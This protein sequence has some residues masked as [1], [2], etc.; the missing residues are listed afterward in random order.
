MSFREIGIVTIHFQSDCKVV[1]REK[2]PNGEDKLKNSHYTS[3]LLKSIETIRS[4]DEETLENVKINSGNRLTFFMFY[5]RN[6]SAT[7]SCCC[8]WA[9]FTYVFCYH[10]L[11]KSIIQ[12]LKNWFFRR[13]FFFFKRFSWKIREKS[14]RTWHFLMLSSRFKKNIPLSTIFTLS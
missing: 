14:I 6:S 2:S 1:A 11:T 9:I 5:L 12:K 4:S 8:G 13:D 3:R 10:L 7:C